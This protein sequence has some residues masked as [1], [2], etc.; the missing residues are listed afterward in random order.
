M[1]L[2]IAAAAFWLGH[3]VASRD[4]KRWKAKWE[5]AVVYWTAKYGS[6]EEGKREA[7]NYDPEL[8]ASA[9]RFMASITRSSR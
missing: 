7:A 3:W 5:A 6:T 2:L 4:A 8:G 1:V 9:K